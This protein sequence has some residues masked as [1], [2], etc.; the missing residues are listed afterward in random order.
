MRLLFN[1]SHLM[2][3][4]LPEHAGSPIPDL[5]ENYRSRIL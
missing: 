1:D 4:A 2:T 3:P 5:I